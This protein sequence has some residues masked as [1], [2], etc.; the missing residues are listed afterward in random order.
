VQNWHAIVSG[1]IRNKKVGP[2]KAKAQKPEDT[3]RQSIKWKDKQRIIS[4]GKS[5]YT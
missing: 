2:T 5:K 3:P 4:R 1:A